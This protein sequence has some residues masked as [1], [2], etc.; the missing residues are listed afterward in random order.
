M[1]KQELRELADDA[2]G[3]M[4]KMITK[5]EDGIKAI[6]KTSHIG[7]AKAIALYERGETLVRD[8]NG[9]IIYRRNKYNMEE[10]RI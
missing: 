9:M 3:T 5:Y 7:I 10:F 2:I 4:G 6:G 1:T 8:M